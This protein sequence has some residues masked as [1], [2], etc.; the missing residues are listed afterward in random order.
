MVV[1]AIQ[2]DVLHSVL[3][4]TDVAQGFNYVVECFCVSRAIFPIGCCVLGLFKHHSLR[5]SPTTFSVNS[6]YLF[7]CVGCIL[8]FN[9]IDLC[10]RPITLDVFRILFQPNIVDVLQAEKKKRFSVK[11]LMDN[12]KIMV[13]IKSAYLVNP[14]KISTYSPVDFGLGVD[15]RGIRSSIHLYYS[16]H[17]SIIVHRYLLPWLQMYDFKNIWRFIDQK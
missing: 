3:S 8:N 2:E 7:I 16:P 10:Q 9:A 11:A 4:G 14:T 5:R 1:R 13:W 12:C 17:V 6:P 15:S